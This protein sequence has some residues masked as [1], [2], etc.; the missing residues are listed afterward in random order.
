MCTCVTT[1][2]LCG[3]TLIPKRGADST[4]NNTFHGG[5]SVLFPDIVL[6]RPDLWLAEHGAKHDLLPLFF[7]E[8]VLQ[9]YD[10]TF[11]VCW[12]VSFCS[13]RRR[14]PWVDCATNETSWRPSVLCATHTGAHRSV[15]S[16]TLCVS[17]LVSCV[18][19]TRIMPK[20]RSN[21]QRNNFP[22]A[23]LSQVVPR[24]FIS[25]DLFFSL[26]H[27][28]LYPW[29][30]FHLSFVFRWSLPG[31][32]RWK[33]WPVYITERSADESKHCCLL[34]GRTSFG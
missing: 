5:I 21:W 28:L 14:F 10:C 11:L 22:L 19:L 29:G 24:W 1:S 4:G 2:H 25:L 13:N 34:L 30:V 17:C 15:S 33:F 3:L 9:T 31:T 8:C 26:F 16:K 23:D 18:K 32:H 6:G 12:N 7:L 20:L 27:S